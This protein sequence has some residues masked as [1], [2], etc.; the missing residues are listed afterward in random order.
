MQIETEG[1]LDKRDTEVSEKFKK[2]SRQVFSPS[3]DKRG[4]AINSKKMKTD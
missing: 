4:T 3:L 1:S 2:K